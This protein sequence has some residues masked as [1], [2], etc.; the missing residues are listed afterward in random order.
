M[1]QR[2]LVEVEILDHTPLIHPL[3]PDRFDTGMG[4]TDNISTE[5]LITCFVLDESLPPS[6]EVIE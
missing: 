6:K 5:T 1:G 2:Y 3:S 4:R